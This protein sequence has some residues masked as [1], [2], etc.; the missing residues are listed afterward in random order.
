ML[1]SSSC[2][3]THR[4]KVSNEVSL[5]SLLL[6]SKEL[7]GHPKHLDSRTEHQRL[8]RHRSIVPAW[9][10]YGE[11]FSFN[12]K[13]FGLGGETP[14]AVQEQVQQQRPTAG[15]ALAGQ[16]TRQTR[17]SDGAVQM[18]PTATRG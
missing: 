10:A 8:P 5:T 1:E 16:A 7:S 17:G 9:C 6:N 4:E 13:D 12:A 14:L 2:W 15:E 11:R 3:F 18:T